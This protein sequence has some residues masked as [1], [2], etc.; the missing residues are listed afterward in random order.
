[1]SCLQKVVEEIERKRRKSYE[2]LYVWSYGM[3]A[4][5]RCRSLFKLSAST[6]LSNKSLTWCYNERHHGKGPMDGVGGTVKNVVFRK[7]KSGQIVIYSPR[8]F[9]EAVNTFVL[10]ILAEHFPESETI[11]EPKGIEA[12]RKIKEILKAHKLERKCNQNGDIYID[13]FEMADDK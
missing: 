2:N 4:E 6:V 7:A 1:M 13:F 8:E 3:G 12:S 9:C 11:I 5:F 10:S